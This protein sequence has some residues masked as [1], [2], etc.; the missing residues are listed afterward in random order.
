M[1][2]IRGFTPF[3]WYNVSIPVHLFLP[4]NLRG[5]VNY[6]HHSHTNNT[7]VEEVYVYLQ[8]NIHRASGFIC[9]SLKE[10]DQKYIDKF[11]QLSENPAPIR[12]I[13]PLIFSSEQT[14]ENKVSNDSYYK[15]VNNY[16]LYF[17][18]KKLSIGSIH[19]LQL[20]LF[21]SLLVQ[22]LVYHHLL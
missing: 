5:V 20:Q 4:S 14:M 21:I 8:E 22:S 18:Q 10:F 13:G 6:I 2:I 3:P 12:F 19:N 7:E 16:Y 1:V 17:R 11:Y 9:N 15:V